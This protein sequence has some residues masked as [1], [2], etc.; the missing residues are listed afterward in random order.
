MDGAKAVTQKASILLKK[1]LGRK[2]AKLDIVE[3]S[4]TNEVNVTSDVEEDPSFTSEAEGSKE[5]GR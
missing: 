5:T 4:D 3:P 1:A 2:V